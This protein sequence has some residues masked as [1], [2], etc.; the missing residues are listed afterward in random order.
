MNQTSA[1][2]PP[3][4]A[5]FDFDGTITT[6][7]MLPDFFRL[8]IPRRRVQFGGVLLAPLIIGYKLGVVSGSLL[9]AAIV[10][11]GFTGVC[12]QSYR[13]HGLDFA[14]SVLPGVIRPEAAERIAWHRARGD[15]VIVVSGALDVYLA[16]WCQTQG[17]ELICSALQHREGR[18]TG[19][20]E[21]SQCVSAR[22]RERV[23]QRVDRSR[24]SE[25]YAYGDT[26]EDRE[27]LELAS[28]RFYQGRE[29]TETPV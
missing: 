17:L 29:V 15:R 6:R 7:E 13:D 9:R 19:R 1:G 27:L 3:A 12:L 26:V 22:K 4:L 2:N 21:G 10:R 5:L 8:A 24:Y 11:L 25:I 16:P 14:R 20:Y 23:L 18:L 28:R